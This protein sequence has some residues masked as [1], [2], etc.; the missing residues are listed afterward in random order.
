MYRVNLNLKLFTDCIKAYIA[1]N[2]SN[3][4]SNIL[5]LVLNQK[6]CTNQTKPDFHVCATAVFLCDL[7]SFGLCIL[8]DDFL[9]WLFQCWENPVV[10]HLCWFPVV[11]P[12]CVGPVASFMILIG[13]LNAARTI[14]SIVDVVL[15]NLVFQTIPPQK[16]WCLENREHKEVY[17]AHAGKRF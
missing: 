12:P 10:I 6:L 16:F 1:L 17:G 3:W 7:K 5:R 4:W 14:F 11:F 9:L 15:V 2:M 8:E 13:E